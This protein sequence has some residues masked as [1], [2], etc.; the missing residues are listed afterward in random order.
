[1]R[2]TLFGTVLYSLYWGF[3]VLCRERNYTATRGK[4]GWGWV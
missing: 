4:M 3:N 2:R 1:M